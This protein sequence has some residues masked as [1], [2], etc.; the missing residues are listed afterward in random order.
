MERPADPRAMNKTYRSRITT[1]SHWMMRHIDHDTRY[2]TINLFQGQANTAAG[3]AAVGGRDNATTT[4]LTQVEQWMLDR[5]R[6][7]CDRHGC[8]PPR[9]ARP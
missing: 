3:L 4:Q 8:P 2:D 9:A 5:I 1:L 6:E 7:H